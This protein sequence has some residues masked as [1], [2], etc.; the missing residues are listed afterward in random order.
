M[1]G[2]RPPGSVAQIISLSLSP[3]SGLKNLPITPDQG[4]THLAILFRASGA[5]LAFLS[6][7][8]GATRK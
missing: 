4:L 2:P 7:R 8:E 6:P 3:F 5:R 1:P